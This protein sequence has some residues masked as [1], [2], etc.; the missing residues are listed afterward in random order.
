MLLSP[1]SW[2]VDET[3]CHVDL[4]MAGSIGFEPIGQVND[5]GLATRCSAPTLPTTQIKQDA[6]FFAIESFVLLKAS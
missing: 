2:G 3:L 1:S 6:H 4:N 5:H